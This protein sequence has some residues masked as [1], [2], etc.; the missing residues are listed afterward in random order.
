MQQTKSAF[1][2]KQ[3]VSAHK[4]ATNHNTLTK[5]F[6]IL[7]ITLFSLIIWS[8]TVAAQEPKPEIESLCGNDNR[9]ASTDPRVGRI[10]YPTGS[11]EQYHCTVWLTASGGLLTA[12][13]C[14]GYLLM[15]GS[16]IEFNV[17]TSLPN[18]SPLAADPNDR[19]PV[20]VGSILATDGGMGNDWAIFAVQPN[21]NTALT[22]YQAQDGFF[23][24]TRANPPTGTTIRVTGFGIDTG[25]Q[26]RTNQTDT[27]PYVG[28]IANRHEY[29]ADTMAG[30]SGSPIIW[31]DN[32]FT[33]GIHTHAGCDNPVIP[34][35]GNIGTSFE[36]DSLEVAL[37]NFH[38]PNV[39]YV[40]QGFP[41]SLL[42]EE[43]PT[44][45]GTVFRPFDTIVHGIET[46]SSG[47]IINIVRGTY[48]ETVTIGAGGRAM[49]LQA[50]VGS[51]IIGN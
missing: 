25:A 49:T 26:N 6:V 12:G 35:D 16:G 38:G 29:Q 28:E 33:V 34:D 19:Y 32:G 5:R 40:D 9:V 18:G 36:L 48:P 44:R 21:P 30:N 17:P 15:P 37:Q 11:N 14:Q 24:M 42:P 51:V 46:A 39:I 8:N 1:R 27:G 22:P 47:A 43:T 13:H 20:E 50:P 4:A 7:I 41:D 31:N 3:I 2:P 10:F 45:N 23:R